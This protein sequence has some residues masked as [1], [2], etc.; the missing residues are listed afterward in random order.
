[1]S[2]TESNFK[3]LGVN[4]DRDFC[5]CCGKQNLKRVVWLEDLR[6]GAI[7]HRGTTCAAYAMLGNRKKGTVEKVLSRGLAV[8]LAKC[9]FAKGW[10]VNQVYQRV[11]NRYGYPL[12]RMADGITLHFSEGDVVVRA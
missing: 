3:V 2:N 10:N 6:T 11:W 7:E 4:D 8:E 9:L 1:M 12:S 5:E